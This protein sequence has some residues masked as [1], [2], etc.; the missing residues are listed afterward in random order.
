LRY[1]LHK[2]EFEAQDFA[3]QHTKRVVRFIDLSDLDFD[4]KRNRV[5]L[6]ID[7][8]CFTN[9]VFKLVQNKRN[10]NFE[11]AILIIVLKNTSFGL[12]IVSLH[13]EVVNNPNRNWDCLATGLMSVDDSNWFYA[14][15]ADGFTVVAVPF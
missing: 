6:R 1:F 7:N 13:L 2:K 9:I 11:R 14:K 3:F 4:I 8:V 10:K 15:T 5:I 12:L